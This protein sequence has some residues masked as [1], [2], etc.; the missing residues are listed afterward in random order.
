MIIAAFISLGIS[1]SFA[2][3]TTGPDIPVND[4][5]FIQT[6]TKSQIRI[7]SYNVNNLFDAEHDDG[8]FDYAFLPKTHPDKLA[9]CQTI[10]QEYYKKQ[11]E[12]TDWTNAKLAQKIKQIVKVIT[13]HGTKPDVLA[14]Q[15]IENENVIKMLAKAAGYSQYV[16]TDYGAH[17]G[18]DVAIL[19]N[20]KKLTLLEEAYVKSPGRDPLR[21]QFR[22][23][24]T[25]E[26]FYVYVNHWLAQSA[27]EEY[28]KETAEALASD[29][30]A[31]NKVQPNVKL[32]ALGDFNVTDDEE[33]DIFNS[34][35]LNKNWKYQLK[36]VHSEARSQFPVLQQNFPNGSYYFSG[37]NI[38]RRFDRFF[39]S[40]S[41]LK[42]TMAKIELSSYRVIY[43][44]FLT[45]LF[46]FKIDFKDPNSDE[47]LVRYP[48]KYNFTDNPKYP[49]GFSDH[50]PISVIVQ[51]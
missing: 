17:R 10:K 25:Q 24:N 19:F 21:A 43:S 27:P 44:E 3:T 35:F 1:L 20:T 42:G 5:F 26:S 23:N 50:L 9:Q 31:L 6:T 47:I 34:T 12:E 51:F 33:A 48:L 38:W 22:I 13:A 16:V 45:G 37:K 40:S 14:L 11:C 7:M 28:R 32:I 41:L 8:A 30:E 2:V 46:A 15:E 36:D 39:V 18:V 49:L 4:A 29:I